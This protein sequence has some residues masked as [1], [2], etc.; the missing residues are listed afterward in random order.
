MKKVGFYLI[1]ASITYLIGQLIWF[2]TILLD[3]PFF[4]NELYEIMFLV[5]IFTLFGIFGLISGI[6]L[7]KIDN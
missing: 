3:E 7:Y 2:L 4:G 1:L 6:K 5:F